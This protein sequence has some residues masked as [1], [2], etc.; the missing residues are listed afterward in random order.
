[1]ITTSC[2]LSI[3]EETR[4]RRLMSEHP[5]IIF[6]PS[7]CCMCHV[8]KKLLATVGVYPTVMELDERETASLRLLS[9]ASPLGT[10]PPRCSLVA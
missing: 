4:F 1:M 8:M 5:V 7:S 9:I 10:L 3:D 6:S 2:C